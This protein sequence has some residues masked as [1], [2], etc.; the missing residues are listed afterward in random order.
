VKGYANKLFATAENR[1]TFPDEKVLAATS[2]AGDLKTDEEPEDWSA[3]F[4]P[5]S[6]A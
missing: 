2:F 6:Q 5:I 1:F 4:N 3:I